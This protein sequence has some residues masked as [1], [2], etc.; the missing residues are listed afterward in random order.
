MEIPYGHCHCGCGEKTTVPKW[1]NP[2]IDYV[3]GVPMR[4]RRGHSGR[5]QERYRVEDRGHTTP[6]WIWQLSTNEWGYGKFDMRV[7]G[8]RK[9]VRAHRW[10]YEQARGSVPN[11]LQ[12]DHLCRVRRCVN[13][14][15]LEPVTAAVN[16]ERSKAARLDVQAVTVIKE[17]L[18]EG[19]TQQSV[20][21]KFG[22]DQ[23]TIGLIARGSTWA[24]VA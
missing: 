1:N 18:R 10:Y 13:P 16:T 8:A 11:G 6:C 23:S 22:V 3:K 4:Y 24:S 7:N 5:V 21:D 9:T 12:L 14:D 2:A 19:R 15:H 20:A 17:L